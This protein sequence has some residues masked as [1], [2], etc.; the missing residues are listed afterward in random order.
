M[1]PSTTLISSLL[2]LSFVCGCSEILVHQAGDIYSVWAAWEQESGE[3]CSVPYWAVVWPAC[4]VVARYLIDHPAICSG[5]RVLDIGC[6]S[7]AAAIAA[8]MSGAQSVTAN[9]R[10]PAALMLAQKN[11]NANN[12]HLE[13]SSE[14]L[15]GNGGAPNTDVIIAADMFYEKSQ[16]A[17]ML[18]WLRSARKTGA[19]VV[20]ADSGR[21]FAPRDGVVCHFSST[22]NVDNDLEGV[23]ERT[24]RVLGLI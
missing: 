4:R 6:G 13:F 21:P 23:V 20:I 19:D 7:G 18:A 11:A 8:K 22:V 1:N 9:D 14:D 12:V 10:D 17:A 24:V 16:A 3:C 15:V 2:P 5:K